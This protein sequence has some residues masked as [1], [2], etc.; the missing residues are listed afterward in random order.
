V[1]GKKKTARVA[2]K[3]TGEPRPGAPEPVEPLMNYRLLVESSLSGIFIVQDYRFVYVNDAF[4]RMHGYQAEEL[5]G[6]PV[7]ETIHPD[8]REEV[9][10]RAA[11]RYAGSPAPLAPVR[12]RLRKDGQVLYTEQAINTIEYNGKVA[13]IGNI[14]DVTDRKQ[15]E[16]E[17]KKAT[18]MLEEAQ[19]LSKVGGWEYDVATHITKWTKET[20]RIYGV[21]TDH[22]SNDISRDISF[23]V[24]EERPKIEA[25]F[26]R[27]VEFGEPYDL[28]LRFTRASGEQIW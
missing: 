25:A 12:R 15:A 8:E 6:M 11:N 18:D 9:T 10:S 27:A 14:I 22:D 19:S 5:L 28:R 7:L 1:A 13:I 24:P 23:Y 4:A 21:D 17:L 2:G 16:A 3:L 20:Y 26:R